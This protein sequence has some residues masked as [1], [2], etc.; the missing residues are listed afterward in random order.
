MD[1]YKG[2]DVITLTEDNLYTKMTEAD[3]LE[4][5]PGQRLSE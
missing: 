3:K 2:I 5:L 4:Y 1:G